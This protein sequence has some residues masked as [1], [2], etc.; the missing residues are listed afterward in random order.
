M[1]DLVPKLEQWNKAD[2]VIGCCEF[3]MF[4][5][6]SMVFGCRKRNY[7]SFQWLIGYYERNK[8]TRSVNVIDGR[9]HYKS[10]C[11]ALQVK[12]CPESQYKYYKRLL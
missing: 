3:Y 12:R 1:R 9:W 10:A 8:M 11:M 4:N 5:K 2:Q 7:K 6:K